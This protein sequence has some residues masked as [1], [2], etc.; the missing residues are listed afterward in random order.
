VDEKRWAL[1]PELRLT[2]GHL[3]YL[4]IGSGSAGG[5]RSTAVQH[6]GNKMAGSIDERVEGCGA[7]AMRQRLGGVL[8]PRMGVA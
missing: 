3:L 1:P 2:E 5:W 7:W 4:C 8:L 6:Q